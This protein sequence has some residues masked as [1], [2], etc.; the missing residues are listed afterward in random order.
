MDNEFGS[1]PVQPSG[2]DERH[3]PLLKRI[4]LYQ[5]QHLAEKHEEIRLK[6]TSSEIRDALEAQSQPVRRLM[7]EEW[8]RNTRPSRLPRLTDFLTPRDTYEVMPAAPDLRGSDYDD[9]FRI[10]LSPASFLP[11]L[12][13]C[14][15]ESW[16][17]DIDVAV[18]FTD[19]D[20]FKP[21]NTRY[22]HSFVDSDLLPTLMRTIEARIYSHGWAYRFA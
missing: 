6:T 3:A 18:A 13:R 17:R 14:R 5:R 11:A 1:Q 19:I 20:D 9:K 2:H 16:L 7:S 8:F 10:L 22:T 12:R 15:I 21:L 4:L